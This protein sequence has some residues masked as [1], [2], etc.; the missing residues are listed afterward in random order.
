MRLQALVPAILFAQSTLALYYCC[1]QIRSKKLWTKVS[2]Q[3]TPGCSKT[4]RLLTKSSGSLRAETIGYV[5]IY[6]D[7]TSCASW[8][9][10]LITG[11]ADFQP[12]SH[13]GVVAATECPP[14]S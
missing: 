1:F 8:H 6:K 5:L 13:V 11:C 4:G 2:R 3:D 7:G 9:T 14:G 12:L 10:Q